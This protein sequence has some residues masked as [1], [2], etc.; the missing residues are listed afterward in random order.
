QYWSPSWVGIA[1]R[2]SYAANEGRTATV[3]PRSNGASITYTGG[4]VYLYYAYHEFKDMTFGASPSTP[5][6]LLPKQNSNNIGGE[7]TFGP[8]K[9]GAGYEKTKR[10]TFTDHKAF[11]GNIV[12]TF[13]SNQLIYQYTKAKDGEVS[14]VTTQPECKVNVVGYQYNFSRRTF[15]Q[16]IY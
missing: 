8:I 1:I 7:F 10:D 3:N 4:P 13:G 2:L 11:L 14:T 16:L 9:L 12:W 6:P 15:S 5:S